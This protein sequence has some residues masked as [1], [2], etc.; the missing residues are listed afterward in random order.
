MYIYE[1]IYNILLNNVF[2]SA[3]TPCGVEIISNMSSKN[4]TFDDQGASPSP[5]P[6]SLKIQFGKS[7]ICPNGYHVPLFTTM[8]P[9][10]KQ[11]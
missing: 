5:S 11:F 3:S 4:G 7:R 10:T 6:K 1:I 8:Q 9:I 2:G